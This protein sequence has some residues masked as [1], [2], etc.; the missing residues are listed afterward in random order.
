MPKL[1]KKYFLN[2]IKFS[3]Y[4]DQSY[5]KTNIFDFRK[6]FDNTKLKIKKIKFS[7]KFLIRV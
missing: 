7:Y 1:K 4:K 5:I 2:K 3:F 6:A